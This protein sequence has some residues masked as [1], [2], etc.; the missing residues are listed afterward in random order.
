MANAN[1]QPA[2][3]FVS[4]CGKDA[5]KCRVFVAE[6]RKAGADVWYDEHNL[7][8]GHVDNNLQSEIRARP[9]FLVFLSPAAL[10]ST[11]VQ[12][13]CYFA[14]QLSGRF[15]ERLFLPIVI[16][17]FDDLDI[18]LWMLRFKRIETRPGEPL[19]EQECIRQMLS[20]L[21]LSSSAEGEG[22]VLPLVDNDVEDLL[23]RGRALQAQERHRE[24][25]VFYDRALELDPD[26][27]IA[28]SQEG[29]AFLLL[30]RY[31]EA[32]AMCEEALKIDPE[33]AWAWL[34]LGHSLAGL[35]RD[36]DAIDAYKRAT[37]VDPSLMSD[38]WYGISATRFRSGHF[39]KGLLAGMIA[40][41][42]GPFGSAGMTGPGFH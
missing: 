2:G 15:K 11:W 8:L 22:D 9:V 39:L 41:R 5:P 20:R 29:Y 18:W 19:P 4:H 37:E 40:D 36:K 23:L 35:S 14:C 31:G 17:P 3:I 24:A 38:A 16:E 13:E 30:D 6:L 32:A 10:A 7:P 27:A 28:L 34:V 26:N 12:D 33:L 25:L 42:F 21:M 1:R